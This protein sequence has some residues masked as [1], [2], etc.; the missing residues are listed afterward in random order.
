MSKYP[1]FRNLS[2]HLNK[3]QN[4]EV[5]S[6]KVLLIFVLMFFFFY[7]TSLYFLILVVL[8]IFFFSKSSIVKNVLEDIFT[9][10]TFGLKKLTQFQ[11]VTAKV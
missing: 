8:H 11:Q 1:C 2:R 4:S 5:Q 7:Q 3:A 9:S 10:S 6:F